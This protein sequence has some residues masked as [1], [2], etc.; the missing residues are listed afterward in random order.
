MLAF[1][2]D[3][4]EGC[5]PK[6][7]EALTRTNLE[8]LPGYGTDRYTLSAK[9][10]IK[11]ACE[12][13]AADVF[14]LT[15]GTQANQVVIA[16][17]L[18]SYEGVIACS[19]G[20]I[21]V[22]EAGAVEETGHKVLTI[23]AKNGKLVATD[24]ENYLKAFYADSS[25][26]H[27]V[28]PGMV[29]LS[30]STEY[31]TLYS[32]KELEAIHQVTLAYRLPLFIDGA[33]LG[34]AL[35][36]PENDVS[37]PEMAKLCEVFYFGGTKYGCL[38]GEAVVFT[39]GAPKHFVTFIKQHGALVAKGR[40]LGVQFDALFSDGLYL[41]VGKSALLLAKRIHDAL[42]EKGYVFPIDSPTNQIFVRMDNEKLESLAKAVW[43]SVWE[44]EDEGHTVIRLC[45]SWATSKESV[46]AL[47]ALL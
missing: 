42:L 3:Y 21:A 18:S 46:D 19:S 9:E 2:N 38:C 1:C 12:D 11:K 5:H 22:H 37:L 20:H 25:S 17:L 29:Y 4:S 8:E 15:G 27:M 40:L 14:F 39:K 24:L 6:I 32:K 16:S 30:Q 23:P 45:T 44:K 33:R 7:L 43:F 31:G 26:D 34:Y 36:T 28:Q 35:C 10:K 47:I 41:E 13:P